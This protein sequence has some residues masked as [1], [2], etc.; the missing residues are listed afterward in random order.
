MVGIK[1]DIDEQGPVSR[2]DGPCHRVHVAVVAH[3]HAFAPERFGNLPVGTPATQLPAPQ[4]NNTFLSAFGQPTRQS[5]C[6]CE[7]QG[8]PSLTQALQL[9]NS[10]TVESRLKS[11]GGKFLQ[12]MAAQKKTDEEIIAHLYL[13]ALCRYPNQ[14]EITK[15]KAY[16]TASTDR[17]SGIED[18]AWS[19]LNLREF[20]FR[21]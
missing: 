21:H 20:V 17:G 7:R 11:G 13:A 14:I 8:Q 5:S 2:R 12:E 3:G 10:Q 9:S 19:V 4:P 1:L 6:T 15:A 18:I 16:L